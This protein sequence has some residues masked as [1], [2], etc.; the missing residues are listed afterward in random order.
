MLT[1]GP[2]C[3][4]ARKRGSRR[5]PSAGWRCAGA[6][7]WLIPARAAAARIS[8]RWRNDADAGAQRP[9]SVLDGPLPGAGGAL[10]PAVAVAD[11]GAGGPFHSRN[12]RRHPV[13]IFN[14]SDLG[15]VSVKKL[16]NNLRPEAAKLKQ[17]QEAIMQEV[18]QLQ[19]NSSTM[20]KEQLE[21]KQQAIQQEQ[22]TFSEK[23]KILQQKEGTR[24]EELSKKFQAKFDSSV[25]EVAKEKGYNMVVTTQAL[26]YSEGVADISNDVVALMNKSSE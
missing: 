2:L 4:T 13:E 24:K 23:A 26:A 21:K 7:W 14:D 8:G 19:Q 5:G 15:S 22:Q 20:T 17:Q 18:Q 11:G 9:G 16:E 12:L 25:R 10:M 1:C 3:F 6:A